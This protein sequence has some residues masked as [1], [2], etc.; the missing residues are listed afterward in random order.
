MEPRRSETFV[1]PTEV[2]V[3][4][5]E[6]RTPP[7]PRFDEKSVQRAQPAVPIGMRARARSWPST[8]ILLC[9]VGGIVGGIL[10]GLALSFF[11]RDGAGARPDSGGTTTVPVGMTE[12]ATSAQPAPQDA[13]PAADGA[14][15]TTPTAAQPAEVAAQPDAASRPVAEQPRANEAAANEATAPADASTEGE[16]RAA[17]G[18]W[19]AATNSRDVGRQMSYYAPKVEAFYLSRN[20]PREAVRAEKTRLFGRA[21]SVNVQ[22]ARPEIQMSRDG[23]TAVMRFRKRYQIAGA[24]SRSGEVL[25]ELR[26]RRTADGW[27]IVGERDLR[28]LQ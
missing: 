24:D 14:V 16:L 5:E 26:W 7:P 11:Q 20:A 25:Q 28:V 19:V 17:L 18:E 12:P 27:K 6:E 22:A 23:R 2:T 15:A 3:P 10:G 9:V 4:L 1:S 8:L 21:S 13:K